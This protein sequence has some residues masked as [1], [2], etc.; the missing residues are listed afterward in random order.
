MNPEPDGRWKVQAMPAEM[1]S[2]ATRLEMP[3]AW[4][5]LQDAA[6]EGVC[7]IPGAVFVHRGGHLAIAA[8]RDA[9]LAMARA[10]LANKLSPAEAL[11]KAWKR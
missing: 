10:C 7:G 5:G 8:T 4:R 9:A 3:T 1:G 2:F 6:L 11:K